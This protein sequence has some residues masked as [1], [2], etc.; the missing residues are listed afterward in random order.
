MLRVEVVLHLEST[1][2]PALQL[3]EPGAEDHELK[4]RDSRTARRTD[5]S[6]PASKLLISEYTGVTPLPPQKGDDQR[7]PGANVKTRREG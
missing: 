3:V 4:H 6:V 2:V 5:R 1:G 7:A